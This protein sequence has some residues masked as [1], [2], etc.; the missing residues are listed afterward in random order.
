MSDLTPLEKE[1]A[2]LAGLGGTVAMSPADAAHF[3]GLSKRSVERLVSSGVIRARRS[4]SRTLIES[5]NCRA[6]LASL[7]AVAGPR[8]AKRPKGGEAAAGPQ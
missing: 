2:R 7:P 1:A 8:M 3:L 5:E 6:Y 4:G